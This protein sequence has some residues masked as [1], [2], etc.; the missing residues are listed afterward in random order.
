MAG[1]DG[2]LAI[3]QDIAD[4]AAALSAVSVDGASGHIGSGGLRML[5]GQSPILR[6][7]EIACSDPTT[8]VSDTWS[9]GAL[10]SAQQQ[11]KDPNPGDWWWTQAKEVA[12]WPN[13]DAPG[14]HSDSNSNGYEV[15]WDAISDSPGH[16]KG[17][18][19]WCICEPWSGRWV[20]LGSNDLAW[21]KLT[22][23]IGDTVA[24]DASA[25]PGVWD[26]TGWGSLTADTGTTITVTDTLGTRTGQ[27]NGK[28]AL[29][30]PVGSEN[31]TVL[32]VLWIETAS[33]QWFQLTENL[34]ATTAHQ[35]SAYPGEWNSTLGGYL[36]ADTGADVTITDTLETRSGG[37]GR[38][39]WCRPMAAVDDADNP[40]I[41]WEIIYLDGVDIQWF[42]LTENLGDSTAHE[43][44][45]HPGVW[46]YSLGGYLYEVTG[47]TETLTDTLETRT[48]GKNCWAA[49][50]LMVG[51]ESGSPVT[52]WE[53]LWIVDSKRLKAKAYG[54]ISTS[55]GY[56]DN[57]S[58]CDGGGI[59]VASTGDGVNLSVNNPLGHYYADDAN[60]WLTPDGSGGWN[61]EPMAQFT[62]RGTLSGALSQGGSASASLT[63]LGTVA[64]YDYLMKSGAPAI[65]SGIPI[66][67]TWYPDAGKFYVDEARCP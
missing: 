43:A 52:S 31:G 26:M 14:W 19:V 10:P 22:E 23:N 24:G 18:W 50:R 45:A 8:P 39:A 9:Q 29:C 66:K 6:L 46:E 60:V 58:S 61:L 11:Y 41:V 56:V 54:A 35:A 44:S 42:K 28:W 13:D 15:I 17:D 32:E 16:N 53:I 27:G 65:A 57:V 2:P 25:N 59:P 36:Y 21:Y 48:G 5:S 62:F 1:A 49:C 55:T 37:V 63:G 4:R 7:F 67:A 20:L 30:R 47:S 34:G 40:I 51:S 12:Y 3:I 64:V 38:W 33:G